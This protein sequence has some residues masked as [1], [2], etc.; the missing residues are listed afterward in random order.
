MKVVETSVPVRD[1]RAEKIR[2]RSTD[3]FRGGTSEY[4]HPPFIHPFHPEL[5]SNMLILAAYVLHTI[6]RDLSSRLT[7][8]NQDSNVVAL[9]PT[10]VRTL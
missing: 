5:E 7:S 10:A 3:S 4:P 8:A 9:G 1:I 6:P 2:R